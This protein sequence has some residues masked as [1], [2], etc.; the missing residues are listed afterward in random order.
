MPARVPT[1]TSEER[2]A[3]FMALSEDLLGRRFWR[4]TA[5]GPISLRG[6]AGFIV[7][8]EVDEEDF[9]SFLLGL[10]P[11]H[12]PRETVYLETLYRDIGPLLATVEARA[13]LDKLRADWTWAVEIGTLR[14]GHNGKPLTPGELADLWFN[15][16]YFHP[17][18]DKRRVL[19]ETSQFGLVAMRFLFV[20]FVLDLAGRVSA[21][22]EFLVEQGFST[23]PS[24]GVPEWGVPTP[25]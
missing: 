25:G 24:R 19:D 7:T 23:Q 15:G 2:L 5:G 18:R 9:R 12:A 1:A 8:P 22:R 16:R 14:I 4:T 11:F 10:R 20:G 21:L 3:L 6:G 17:D 13:A